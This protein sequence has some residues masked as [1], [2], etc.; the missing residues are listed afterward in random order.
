MIM[1]KKNSVMREGIAYL[2]F[3][4]LTTVIDYVI[5]N[6]LFYWTN[7]PTIPAQTIAWV[8][9]VL[10]AFVTNKWWVFESRTLVP[11]EVWKEFV[12]FVACRIATF[13][14][15]LAA[16]FIMVDL[17]GMEFFICKLLIS[18]VVVILNYVFSKILIFAK[19]DKK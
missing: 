11:A 14:F 7:V 16:L 1:E 18:V 3:G 2:I 12:S 10:F 5:S 4:V 13:I 19:K 15:N 9:A 17:I 6:A 8:A